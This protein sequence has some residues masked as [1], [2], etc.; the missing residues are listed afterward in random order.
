[1]SV[2]DWFSAGRL[3]EKIAITVDDGIRC[4]LR[5]LF[6]ALAAENTPGAVFLCRRALQ[7]GFRGETKCER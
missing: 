1:M 4:T 3:A 7:G 5:N 6:F 2:D